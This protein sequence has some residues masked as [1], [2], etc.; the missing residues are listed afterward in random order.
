MGAWR[1]SKG[2]YK[3]DPLF[4]GAVFPMGMYAVS[5]H[6]LVEATHFY[7]LSIIADIFVYIALSAWLY[8]FAGLVYTII[9]KL[10]TASSSN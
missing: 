5:T 6:M 7:Q 4:W 8:Q 2:Y 10:T 3:Y 9:K 1:L